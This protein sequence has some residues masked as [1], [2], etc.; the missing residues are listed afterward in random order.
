MHRWK[1]QELDHKRNC[2]LWQT[3]TSLKQ[4][5]K[6]HVAVPTHFWHFLRAFP[7]SLSHTLAQIRPVHLLTTQQLLP[8]AV[9][10][11]GWQMCTPYASLPCTCPPSGKS[12]SV[13]PMLLKSDGRDTTC[14]TSLFRV[15]W[16]SETLLEKPGAPLDSSQWLVG[17]C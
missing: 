16:V 17:L 11:E 13:V 1:Q 15:P 2:R 14:M 4:L 7:N 12:H 5:S 3:S 10:W 9:D 6:S 8:Q